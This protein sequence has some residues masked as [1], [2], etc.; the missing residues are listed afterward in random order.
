M[1]KDWD[2]I[3]SENPLNEERVATYERLME[4]QERIAAGLRGVSREALAR[5]LTASDL[6]ASLLE[7]ED[8]LYLRSLARFINALAD[9]L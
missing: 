4:A 5:A 8:E 2:T 9:E 6:D 1:A 7:S 3:K